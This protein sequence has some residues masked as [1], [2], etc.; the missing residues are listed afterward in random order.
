MLDQRRAHLVEQRIAPNVTLPILGASIS[1]DRRP[2]GWETSNLYDP[3]SP[4]YV[5]KRFELDGVGGVTT[6]VR[7]EA[8]RSVYRKIARDC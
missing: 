7:A 6:L 5:G 8:H 4:A 1:S 3:E 2:L